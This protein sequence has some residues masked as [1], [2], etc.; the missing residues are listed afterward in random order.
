M[1][2]LRESKNKSLTSIGLITGVEN[3][4]LIIWVVKVGGVHPVVL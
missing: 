1:D 3:A 4:S 2:D